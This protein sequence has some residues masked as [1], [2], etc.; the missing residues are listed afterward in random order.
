MFRVPHDKFS[1]ILK[2]HWTA[3]CFCGGW[4][5]GGFNISHLPGNKI[6][7]SNK[8]QTA[9]RLDWLSLQRLHGDLELFKLL[10]NR[11]DTGLRLLRSRIKIHI[12]ICVLQQRGGVTAVNWV[13]TD[14][15]W[16]SKN[17][18]PLTDIDFENCERNGKYQLSKM[19]GGTKRKNF[20]VFIKTEKYA[21]QQNWLF[22]ERLQF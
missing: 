13:P 22:P 18:M 20:S 10:N 17:H 14:F 16:I 2:R 15:F 1:F 19:H 5:G 11:G 21:N 4:G 9:C 6:Y 8:K 12:V 7:Q 3:N